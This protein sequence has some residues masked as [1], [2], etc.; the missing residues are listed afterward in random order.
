MMPVVFLVGIKYLIA[1]Y[2]HL[3]VHYD[4]IPSNMQ[5]AGVFRGIAGMCI[6]F[7][8]A[9]IVDEIHRR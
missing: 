5:G 1:I 2:G 8:G 3:D 4:N 6:G 9:E 7:L